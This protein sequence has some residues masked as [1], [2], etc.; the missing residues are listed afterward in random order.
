MRSSNQL[1]AS[2]VAIFS[3]HRVLFSPPL[4]SLRLFPPRC[5][6]EVPVTTGA[7]PTQM[8]RQ[9]AVSAAPPPT[10]TGG[11]PTPPPWP[12]HDEKCSTGTPE[13]LARARTMTPR[14]KYAGK[15]RETLFPSFRTA[16]GD[17]AKFPRTLLST[18]DSPF[19][20][21]FPLLK[22]KKKKNLK[23]ILMHFRMFI[24]PD[25]CAGTRLEMR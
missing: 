3:N 5:E 18:S 24:H 22:K 7:V 2:C 9:R 15:Y 17:G 13:K 4:P 11:P 19:A 12:Q 10:P 6:T 25:G 8:D 16:T 21:R 14:C 20:R 1:L 23:K